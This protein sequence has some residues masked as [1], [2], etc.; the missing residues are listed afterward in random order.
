[1]TGLLQNLSDRGDLQRDP[2]N[3]PLTPLQALVDEG[4]GD[5]FGPQDFYRRSSDSTFDRVVGGVNQA[6][7]VIGL[8][9]ILCSY[10]KPLR[11]LSAAG[12]GFLSRPR[13]AGFLL[14]TGGLSLLRQAPYAYEAG[15]RLFGSYPADSK[16][17]RITDL[18]EVGGWSVGALGILVG[19]GSFVAGEL[20]YLKTRE[21]LLSEEGMALSYARQKAWMRGDGVRRAFNDPE[22]WE[23]LARGNLNLSTTQRD[24][25]IRAS[26]L[27]NHA[28][29][30]GSAAVGAGQFAMGAY[31][32]HDHSQKTGKLE[33]G[34]IASLFFHLALDVAPGV[35]ML[36]YRAGRGHRESNLGPA[37]SE[38]IQRGMHKDPKLR[39]NVIF[40][41]EKGIPLFP[42]EQRS[43]FIRTG[44]EQLGELEA[45][46][47]EAR[48]L[49]VL[50]PSP[51][52]SPVGNGRWDPSVAERFKAQFLSSHSRLTPP[53]ANRPL[54][55]Y[56]FENYRWVYKHG[57]LTPLEVLDKIVE[58]PSSSNGAIIPRSIEKGRGLY[59]I[60]AGAAHKNQTLYQMGVP[61][62]EGGIPIGL[63]DLTQGVD[64]IMYAGSKTLR[65]T[66]VGES[67]VLKIAKERGFMIVPLGMTALANGGTGDDHGYGYV[68]N[69]L[70]PEMIT[71]GSSGAAG[72]VIPL[73]YNPIA[74][75]ITSD[76][77]GSTTAP[78]GTAGAWSIVP[79][80]SIISTKG[81]LGFEPTR[82]DRIGVMAWHPQDCIEL[83]LC[84][85][86]RVGN[87][88]H[89]QIE[90]PGLLF[91]PSTRR[92]RLLYLQDLLE[93][94]SPEAKAHFLDQIQRFQRQ[95]YEVIP[96]GPEWNFLTAPVTLY[97]YVAYLGLA[98][99]YTNPLLFNRF[100]PPK[101]TLDYNVETRLAKAHAS[102]RSGLDHKAWELA[103]I[104][105]DLVR[106][107]LG[108][109]VIILSTSPEA[110]PTQH[111]KEGTAGALLDGHD[112]RTM[113][114][115]FVEDFGQINAPG[116]QNRRVGITATGRLPDLMHFFQT[117]Q[118]AAAI[119]L[120]TRAS[121][122]PRPDSKAPPPPPLFRL[123]AFEPEMGRVP[124]DSLGQI[125]VHEGTSN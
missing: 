38:E 13:V 123:P 97:P 86:Q 6:A 107:K 10:A 21:M 48:S 7:A 118:D 113:L 103:D 72:H 60:L 3:Q 47:R 61:L 43:E 96:L 75:A 82:L 59:K 26:R 81:F 95:G 99:N 30:G 58:E 65:V 110:F 34:S 31:D 33:A 92:P 51:A 20:K 45:T 18:L 117:Y 42:T 76:T 90:N 19:A 125:G 54:G 108:E 100:G 84:L 17:S 85:S 93:T 55:Y 14:I 121:E 28:L 69:S 9:S 29:L 111:L 80:R 49:P 87:D 106:E 35:N 15:G 116:Q 2:S 41:L 66:G 77:G 70:R 79:P 68:G 104:F 25:I 67:P 124:D 109:G 8:V 57:A 27:T 16:H 105:Q 101:R 22:T 91:A 114:K 23:Q 63:K 40:D 62:P 102:M 44:W 94:S 74:A 71:A 115:N 52:E 88:P 37:V 98:Y 39:K 24:W 1:V 64:G 78:A 46:F 119:S 89:M 120:V 73:P 112:A 36:L 12:I 5:F 83:A 32:L 122:G 56:S 53:P 4:V 11:P 50:S